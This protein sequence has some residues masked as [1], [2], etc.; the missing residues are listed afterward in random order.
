MDKI[1]SFRDLKIWQK[2]IEIVKDV[3][4]LTKDF[5]KEEIY[6]LTAQMRRSAISMPSN[7]AEGFKRYGKDFK[8]FLQISLGSAAELETQLIIARELSFV[9]E[10]NLKNIVNKLDHLSRMTKSLLNKISN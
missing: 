3:Y 6:G 1:E 2:G 5:P 8:R 9:S 7:T 4:T 10:D